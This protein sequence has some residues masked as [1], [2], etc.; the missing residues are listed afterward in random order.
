MLIYNA[1]K[2]CNFLTKSLTQQFAYFASLGHGELSA[3][4]YKFQG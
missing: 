1:G 4:K 2:F 3:K